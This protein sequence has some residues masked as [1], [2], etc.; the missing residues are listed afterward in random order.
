MLRRCLPDRQLPLTVNSPS[1]H[2][3][4]RFYGAMGLGAVVAGAVNL[5]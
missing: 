1:V 3:Y 5:G 2:R 4:G